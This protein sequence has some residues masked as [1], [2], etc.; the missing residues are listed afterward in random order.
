M[1]AKSSW[2]LQ[3]QGVL[4]QVRAIDVPV[5]DRSLCEQLFGVR[6]RRAIELMHFFGGYQSGNTIVL[7][8]TDLIRRLEGLRSNPEFQQERER[9]MRLSERLTSM[10]QQHPAASFGI[11][12]IPS[13]VSAVPSGVAF[14]NAQMIVDY[15]N[16]EDLFAKLYALAQAAASDLAAFRMLTD[17]PDQVRR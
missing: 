13:C 3:I 10:R 16:L 2:L 14:A 17:A 8:R 11:P 5:I 9:K 4:E 7:D 6:R 12:N 15:T 1:P